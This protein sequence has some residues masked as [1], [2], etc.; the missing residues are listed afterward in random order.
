MQLRITFLPFWL[1][2]ILTYCILVSCNNKEDTKISEEK[3]SSMPV[4]SLEL[5]IQSELGEGAYWDHQS[6][7]FYWV[8]I[9][10]KKVHRY[11]PKTKINESF[12]TP[13]RV[14]TVVPK[15]DTVAVVALDDGIYLLNT[16]SKQIDLLSDIEKTYTINRFN[17]GKCD[18]LGNL[19]VG[20]MNLEESNASGKVYKITEAGQTTMMID[21]VTISNGIVWTKDGKTMYYIDTPTSEIRAYDFDLETAQISNRRTAVKVPISLG[22]P[23][24][25][26]IDEDDK[27]WVG[28]WNG[29][30]VAQ[31]DPV[32]GELLSTIAVPAHNVTACAFGGPA[33]D[34][35]YITTARADMTEEETAKY[36]LAGSIF[37]AEPGVKGVPTTR[38]GN[39]AKN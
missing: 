33:L 15:N 5:E 39:S 29:N 37:V 6:G 30:A 31:F 34:K 32:T 10:G 11:N 8:D 24:G 9:L 35:L 16:K 19:W 4:A 12:D 3:K 2:I 27:L 20:S 23:D 14:G 38:F 21:S 28:M 25:M 36:P 1:L 7:L 22:F 17:D 18:S 26:T 13:S